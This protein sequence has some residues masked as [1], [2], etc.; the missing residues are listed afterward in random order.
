MTDS[1]A[2]GKPTL[3]PTLRY[4][5]APAAIDWLERAFGFERLAVHA[6]PDNTV[7]HAELR[8]GSGVIMLGSSRPDSFGRSPREL[9]GVTG[10]IYV[11]VQ[12][13]DAHYRRAREAGA[14]IIRELNDTDYGSREYSAKDPEGYIWSFG[15]YQP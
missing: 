10:G 11:A 6:G 15:T 5:D 2:N 12:D 4:T 13:P 8:Y 14:E 1:T 9:G 7:A 3:Y